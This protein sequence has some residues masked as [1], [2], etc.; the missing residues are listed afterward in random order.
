MQPRYLAPC[1]KC[2]FCGWCLT[3]LQTFLDKSA[4]DG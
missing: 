2:G 1:I 3:A 4:G